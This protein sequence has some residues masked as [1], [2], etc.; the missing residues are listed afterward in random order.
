MPKPEKALVRSPSPAAAGSFFSTCKLWMPS[1]PRRKGLPQSLASVLGLLEQ[2]RRDRSEVAPQSIELIQQFQD[3][4][5]GVVVDFHV[6]PEFTDQANSSEV[7]LVEEGTCL[8]LRRHDPAAL[9]PLAQLPEGDRA[10]DFDDFPF[11]QLH[12]ALRSV[13]R[14]S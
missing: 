14:G 13:S 4:R 6:A 2:R 3:D 8:A 10:E 1:A 12:E 5:H 9:H 7:D 11:A